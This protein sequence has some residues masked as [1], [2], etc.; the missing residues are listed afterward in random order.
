MSMT[1]EE[2]KRLA[3]DIC[4]NRVFTDR[5]INEKDA[6]LTPMIFMPL[7]L[8][9][10]STIDLD[11]VQVKKKRKEID[12]M[13]MIYEYISEAGPR[14]INGYP[15]FF[16]MKVLT[17]SDWPKFVEYIKAYQAFKENYNSSA[18]GEE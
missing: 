17:K 2:L 13:A 7:G 11:N 1:N 14:G 12:E 15:C 18:K 16:S 6:E 8:G 4:E 10:L 9:A 5:H 3:E